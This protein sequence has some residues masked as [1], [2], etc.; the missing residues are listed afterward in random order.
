MY[1][2]KSWDWR[3]KIA[4]DTQLENSLINFSKILLPDERNL[5]I[6]TINHFKKNYSIGM[7]LD[8]CIDN[9]SKACLAISKANSKLSNL[10]YCPKFLKSYYIKKIDSSNLTQKKEL[11]YLL[12]HAILHGK[13]DINHN[14]FLTKLFGP[15]YTKMIEK[16][17]KTNILRI[18]PSFFNQA[19]THFFRFYISRRIFSP[20]IR[21]IL[22]SFFK[23]NNLTYHQYA[24]LPNSISQVL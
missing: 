8:Y 15:Y 12:N 24:Y 22:Q 13:K 4:F 19:F 5:F 11:K 6:N 16:L 17:E 7:L 21:Y 9:P 2:I 18:F 23:C 20:S 10:I 3:Y 1:I 14:S